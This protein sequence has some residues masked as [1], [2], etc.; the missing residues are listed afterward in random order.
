M[1]TWKAQTVVRGQRSRSAVR[2]ARVVFYIP[3]VLGPIITG[4]VVVAQATTDEYRL[5]AAFLYRFPQFVEWPSQA[6]ENRPTVDLCVAEP[7]PFGTTIDDLVRGES[8]DGRPLVVR[9]VD[10]SNVSGCHVL[11]LPSEFRA[12][13]MTLQRIET[14]PVLT[15]SDAPEFLD[16]GG[17]VQLR[18]LDNRVRFQ[19]NAG[20]ADRAGLRLSAQLLR[21][22]LDVRRPGS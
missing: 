14:S 1:V 22:A 12:R 8:L 11:Y 3:I 16:E 10:G 4:P 15:V 17:I 18:L 9:R 13:R 6:V 2:A 19:I 20:A 5:K 7:N 21:L